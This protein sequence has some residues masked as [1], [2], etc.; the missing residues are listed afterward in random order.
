MWG[1][2]PQLE[3]FRERLKVLLEAHE[4]DLNPQ[5]ITAEEG[6]VLCRQG[7]PVDTLMLLRETLEAVNLHQEQLVHTLAEVDAI[8][9]MGEVGF[10]PMG[11]TTPTCECSH[12]SARE[13]SVE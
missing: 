6:T 13:Q 8:E 2:E 3:A 10:S 11:S 1:D 5:I 4:Q 7:E 12:S 9:Q